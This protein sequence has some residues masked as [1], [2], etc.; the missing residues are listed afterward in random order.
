MRARLCRAAAALVLV[1]ASTLA[2]GMINPAPPAN[3]A[4]GD[5]IVVRWN[6]MLLD[7]VRHSTLGPPMVARALAIAHTCMYDAWAAYDLLA[8]GTP[9]RRPAAPAAAGMDRG[10]Q[11]QGDQ[12]RRPIVRRSTCSPA[13]SPS[14]TPSCPRSA[15][16]P[17]SSRPTPPRRPA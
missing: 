10:E 9:L 14:S 15:S 3:A 12:L 1:V 4:A 16:I 17:T 6:E 2:G 8:A 13:V 5:T 11:D 7:S